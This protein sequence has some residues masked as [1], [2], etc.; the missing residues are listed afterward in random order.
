MVPTTVCFP[1]YVCVCVLYIIHTLIV[2][3]CYDCALFS[4]SLALAGIII[5]YFALLKY[6]L[7]TNVQCSCNSSD[8]RILHFRLLSFWALSIISIIILK[9][10]FRNFKLQTLH[11]RHRDQIMLV[12]GEFIALAP[13]L[14]SGF[15]SLLWQRIM[16]MAIAMM[17]ITPPMTPVS[18][19]RRGKFSV[20]KG[21]FIC[22]EILCSFCKKILYRNLVAILF[23]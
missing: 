18:I 7:C 22:S 12:K 6:M 9:N 20:K 23:V 4:S 3:L 14:P 5:M 1:L 13:S 11:S 2:I 17:T 21:V 8:S 16:T 15:F 19:M 10:C